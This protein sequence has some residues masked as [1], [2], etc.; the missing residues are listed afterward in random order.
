LALA[1]IA[2]GIGPIRDFVETGYVLRV[3]RAILAVGLGTLSIVFL[4]AGLILDTISKLHQETIELWKQ[5][6]RDRR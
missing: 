6:L 2:S 3:P 4:T 5:V 1:S